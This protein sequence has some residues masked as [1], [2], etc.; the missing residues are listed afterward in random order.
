MRF[1][2][3]YLIIPPCEH[4]M[5]QC[6]DLICWISESTALIVN[7]PRRGL[8]EVNNAPRPLSLPTITQRTQ[9]IR[10][11]SLSGLELHLS[12]FHVIGDADLT[13]LKLWVD[14]FKGFKDTCCSFDKQ[15][16]RCPWLDGKTTLKSSPSF[17]KQDLLKTE[18]N[19]I[20]IQPNVIIKLQK[21]TIVM[22]V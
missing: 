11:V 18:K 1:A 4:L 17:F 22:T 10:N 16:G 19:W 15:A 6:W 8:Y 9:L 20:T 14:A 5:E 7:S 21:T 12:L 13:A 2:T 3:S